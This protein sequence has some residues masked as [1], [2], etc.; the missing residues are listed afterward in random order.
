M[1]TYATLTGPVLDLTDRTEAEQR[2]LEQA[3]AAY[4][5]G[6]DWA[7][8]NNTF[9]SG[10]ANP[11]L[12]GG[13]ITEEAWANPVFRSVRDLGARLGIAQGRVAPEGE[14]ATD[15]LRDDWVSVAEAAAR[16]GV[17]V[18]GLH[19]AI[20]RGAVVARPSKRGGSWLM[21][22]TNSLARWTPDPARQ[23]ARRPGSRPAA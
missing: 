16:K 19:R 6:I 18:P 7:E 21:V 23:A 22:S 10:T 9:V 3:L 4:R 12:R 5:A 14:P 20:K 2:Y 17:S 8:F 15:P 11:L 13:M 1:R